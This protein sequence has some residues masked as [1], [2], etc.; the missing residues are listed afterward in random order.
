MHVLSGAGLQGYRWPP[1]LPA[2]AA[3]WCSRRKIRPAIMLLAE[4]LPLPI[5][6]LGE[7][8]VRRL[9]ALSLPE[10]AAP[11]R[12]DR[13]PCAALHPALHISSAAEA[14]ALAALECVHKRFGCDFASLTGERSKRACSDSQNRPGPLRDGDPRQGCAQSLMQTPCFKGICATCANAA[15]IWFADRESSAFRGLAKN[16][17]LIAKARATRHRLS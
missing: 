12:D 17:F 4:A 5:F 1:G 2:M 16:G 7:Q 3:S 9:T 14:E 13:A 6:G 10:L 8:I 11:P 15:A